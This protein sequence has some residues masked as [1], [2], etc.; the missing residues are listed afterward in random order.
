[1]S[2][3]DKIKQEQQDSETL[4]SLTLRLDAVEAHER[5]LTKSV[6]AMSGFLKVMDE[7][8]TAAIN[9]VKELIS[10][11]HEQPS[12][13]QLD[14]ETK[15]RLNEIEKTLAEVA[16]QLSLSGAVK[17]SD[18]STVTQSD[19]QA[20]SMMKQ[21]NQKMTTMTTASESQ[22]ES[23]EKWFKWLIAAVK[24]KST[25]QVDADKVADVVAQQVTE[26]FDQAVQKPV[27]GLRSDLEGFREEMGALGAE[28]LSEAR[29]EL[30]GLL[31][32]MRGVEEM[33]KRYERQVNFVS[34]SRIALALIPLLIA[35][36]LVGGLV[37]G[38]GSM[39]GIGPLFGWIW[40]SF[41]AASLWWHKL[42]IA[43]G[44]LG[45]AALFVWIV[46][47]VSQWVHKELR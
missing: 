42:L 38:F 46:L 18:G 16:K 1:M 37:W 19:L 3:L 12:Q 6:N 20:L 9:Q 35:L 26:H 15:I 22:K 4:A 14:D 45:A 36:I 23:N 34:V 30:Q 43:L 21:I 39:V 17:L 28:R 11:Q 41:T 7:A 44:G 2:A 32:E 13:T 10:Q 33:V 24:A 40:A 8:L 31:S 27:E 47:R 25:V 5:E 29:T